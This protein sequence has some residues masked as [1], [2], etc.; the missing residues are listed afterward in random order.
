MLVRSVRLSGPV[1]APDFDMIQPQLSFRIGAP[2]VHLPDD[3][4]ATINDLA[5]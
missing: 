1:T 5:N 3:D 2:P 4:N